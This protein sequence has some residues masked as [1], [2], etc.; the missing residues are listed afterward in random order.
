[1]KN[2]ISQSARTGKS[3]L[4]R[5][6]RARS[7]RREGVACPEGRGLASGAGAESMQRTSPCRLQRTGRPGGKGFA[8]ST[9]L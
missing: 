5:S 2:R 1:M 8:K 7:I 4:H 6:R 3:G 9:G